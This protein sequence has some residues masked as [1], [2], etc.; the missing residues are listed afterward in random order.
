MSFLK[1]T[2]DNHRALPMAKQTL[3]DG[4]VLK[5]IDTGVLLVMPAEE[6]VSAHKLVIS[7]GIHGNETAPME[8]VDGLISSIYDGQLKVRTPVLF[9]I[10]NPLAA[11]EQ[12]RF[13]DDNLNRLFDGQHR[14]YNSPEAARAKL[15]E[16]VVSDFYS[17]DTFSTDTFSKDLGPTGMRLHYD[18]HTAIRGSEL[19]KFAV[20]PYLNDRSWNKLQIGFLEQCG[21][22]GVLLSNQPAGTFS[23]FTSHRFGAHSFT[24][25]LGKV[26]K[27]GENDMSKF[28]A[29]DQGLRK[30]ISGAEG[31]N[32][33][34][35]SI[36][37][38]SVVEEVIKR[39]D[40]LQLHIADDA[41][42][43]TEFPVNSL[44]A[45]DVDYEYRTRVDGERFVFPIK[46]VPCGQRAMLVVAPTKLD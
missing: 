3:I 13:V 22:E 19:E 38:F 17:T 6:S 37:L 14:D 20:Y 27:F 32:N 31:F 43:F 18:L 46:N 24:I 8:I 5:T 4:T 45:S 7:S 40:A 12:V 29:M 10:G 26:R 41:K 30:I 1:K 35:R 23:Y 25:E 16:E 15:L 9:I 2:I 36:K 33:E 21:I 42:N 28:D 11:K 39:S 34:V 44:L